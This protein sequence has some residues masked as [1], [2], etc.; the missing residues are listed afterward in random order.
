MLLL[1]DAQIDP[2][3]IMLSWEV[4]DCYAQYT[5]ICSIT[6][7]LWNPMQRELES[8]HSAVCFQTICMEHK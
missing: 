7:T 4:L 5:V 8:R 6:A 1:A 2:M 3:N